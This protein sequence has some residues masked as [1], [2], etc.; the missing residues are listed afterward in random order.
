MRLRRSLRTVFACSLLASG[1]LG[2]GQGE[3]ERSPGLRGEPPPLPQLTL[4]ATETLDLSPWFS[5]ASGSELV[6]V[7]VAPNGDRYVLDKSSG[8]HLLRAEG[9][10]LVLDSRNIEARYGLSPD[11]ELTD[12]VA[13]GEDRFLITAENDGFLLDLWAGSMRSHF[14]YFPER[15]GEVAGVEPPSISVSQV[16]ASS[17]IPVKQRTESVTVNLN[18]GQIFAQP[19]TFRLDVLSSESSLAGSELFVFAP[20]GGQPM[21]VTEL[22]DPGFVAGGMAAIRDRL[23]VGFRDG[24]YELS[25]GGEVA[26]PI[27]TLD[28]GV[29]VTGMALDGEQLLLLDGP[30]RRLII[31]EL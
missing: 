2:C 30:G 8:L 5:D 3:G 17:G 13:Y 19:Q 6:G 16:L 25:F 11:L 27:L 28:A 23:V 14:C 15:G 7:A 4:T 24:L 1:L 31:V 9:T 22:S 12:V 29:V 10:E 21:Q 26:A 20:A 18:S